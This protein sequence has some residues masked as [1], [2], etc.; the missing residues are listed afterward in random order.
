LRANAVVYWLGV[1]KEADMADLI[2]VSALFAFFAI[3]GLF[4]VACDKIIG[5][6]DVALREGLTSTPTPEPEVEERRAAA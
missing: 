2:Y 5:P 6:D 4:V 1:P 3:A